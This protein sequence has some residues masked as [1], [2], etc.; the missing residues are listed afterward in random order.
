MTACFWLAPPCSSWNSACGCC[1]A[2]KEGSLFAGYICIYVW[3]K[4]SELCYALRLEWLPPS[5]LVFI[6]S[7]QILCS[8]TQL[9]VSTSLK[10]LLP[11]GMFY[12]GVRWRKFNQPQTG[13]SEA[14]RC[15]NDAFP[16]QRRKEIPSKALIAHS[17]AVK[18]RSDSSP[19]SLNA[20]C[21]SSPR[22]R[23]WT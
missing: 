4:V 7:P 14:W 11:K 23:S 8:L 20:S 6:L 9:M 10:E 16:P 17:R 1:C 2:G 21:F 22:E 5:R 18:A 19:V 13:G 12:I 3:K 15:A